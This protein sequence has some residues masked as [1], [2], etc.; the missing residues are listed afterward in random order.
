VLH[1]YR[2][3][4]YL[5]LI[6]KS[7][8]TF[9]KAFF[10]T[11]KSIIIFAIM[12]S[13]LFGNG[14]LD[15]V[16]KNVTTEMA[17]I[18]EST[19]V[20]MDNSRYDSALS[21]LSQGFYLHNE[22]V[23]P[24]D[25][26]Y[27]HSIEAEIMYYNAL[28]DIGLSSVQQSVILAK[29]LKNDTLIG[30]TENLLG[31]FLMNLN[32]DSEAVSHLKIASK[33]LPTY[34]GKG[35][36]AQQY[37]ALSNLGEC[38]LKLDKLDSAIY[39]SELAIPEA[40]FYERVRG[41]ALA[42]WN[43]GEALIEQNKLNDAETRL[44]HALNIIENT[45]HIDVAQT[46]C[47]SLMK[48][49]AAKANSEKSM[50]WLEKGL[51]KG[52]NQLNT[53]LSRIN[54]LEAAI[55]VSIQL[56]NTD[57]ANSLLKELYTLQDALNKKQQ[58]QRVFVL[59]EYFKKNQNIDLLN[60]L[61]SSQKEEITVRKKA[62]ILII[63]LFF[64]VVA[65]AF[66]F[67]R[68]MKQ[69]QKITELQHKQEVQKNEKENELK[70]LKTKMKAVYDERNRISTDLHDDIGAALSSIRIYSDAALRQF[71]KKPEESE[72]LMSRIKTSSGEMMEK[73]SDIIW[74]INPQNDSG[75]NLILRMK[76]HLSEL[77]SGYE[78]NYNFE[79]NQEAETFLLSTHARR[80]M[81]LVFKE[82][83]NNMI[84]Y[85]EAK[86]LAVIMKLNDDKLHFSLIDN[87]KGF[88]LAKISA[89]NGLSNMARRI[90]D[91]GAHFEIQS[92]PNEGCAIKCTLDIA[93][94]RE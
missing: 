13:S 33:L 2:L 8:L 78:F 53:D 75:E 28:F 91:L 60:K 68:G 88:N 57:L 4:K 63:I 73:M 62:E 56:K 1:N 80:N 67:Y 30:N 40:T 11:K 9:E 71:E 64:S 50:F 27:L 47:S 83:V 44:S 87:G 43:I 34:H 18:L 36:L 31:L 82:A 37:H 19:F 29:E 21:I 51:E 54:F 92:S 74:A 38:Y 6:D 15:Y 86:N 45:V 24:I 10:M 35:Y 79:V 76:T 90:N 65:F 46:L 66:A 61:N 93:K 69:K 52:K 41:I 81:Y 7:L 89:G 59:Q 84:K 12:L 26:Y 22:I 49:E 85:S 77:S 32:R 72:K 14:Q 20:Q 70:A 23:V 16:P 3:S 17:K 48:L 25:Q 5:Q 39:Y 42:E 55:N 58:N 94:I